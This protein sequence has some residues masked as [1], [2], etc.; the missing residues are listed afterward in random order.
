[1]EWL[2]EVCGSAHSLFFQTGFRVDIVEGFSRS[3]E[4]PG[5]DLMG[6]E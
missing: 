5:L 4:E 2:T 6:S 1:M 3:A